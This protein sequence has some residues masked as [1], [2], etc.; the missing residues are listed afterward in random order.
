MMA[1][2]Q[3]GLEIIPDLSIMSLYDIDLTSE[4]LEH[5]LKEDIEM[6]NKANP[7]IVKKK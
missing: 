2:T 1:E 7:E 5:F 3:Y 4:Y 6:F